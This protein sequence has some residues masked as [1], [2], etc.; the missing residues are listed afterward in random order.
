MSPEGLLCVDRA[1]PYDMRLQTGVSLKGN[2]I[3]EISQYKA[4]PNALSDA[5]L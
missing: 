4:I 3:Q 5:P 1:Y 2:Q